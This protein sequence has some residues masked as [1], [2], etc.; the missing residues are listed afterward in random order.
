MKE[1]QVDDSSKKLEARSRS[2]CSEWTTY[3]Q[4]NI[5]HLRGGQ[6]RIPQSEKDRLH[7]ALQLPLPVTDFSIAA[8][9]IRELIGVFLNESVHEPERIGFCE[10]RAV[11]DSSLMISAEHLLTSFIAMRTFLES[12]LTDSQKDE[13]IIRIYCDS[14]HSLEDVI[15]ITR[16]A[17]TA[18]GG[19]REEYIEPLAFELLEFRAVLV[20]K[21]LELGAHIVSSRVQAEV[22]V[23]TIESEPEALILTIGEDSLLHQMLERQ[24]ELRKEVLPSIQKTAL[25]LVQHLLAFIETVR[26]QEVQPIGFD[27]KGMGKNKPISAEGVLDNLRETLYQLDDH[28]EALSEETPM[29]I[30]FRAYLHNMSH[31]ISAF[32]IALIRQ[33]R[34]GYIPEGV[35]EVV[36]QQAQYAFREVTQA[37][38]QL[39][40]IAN[41]DLFESERG[42]VVRTAGKVA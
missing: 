23:N 7:S 30:N 21:A 33:K 26:N 27:Q 14:H 31:F 36:Q 4:P 32:R 41:V 17:S 18:E 40:T 16:K 15:E 25:T 42:G 2:D 8:F 10:Q 12:E 24:A 13:H 20:S 3:S 37:V 34:N 35:C 28:F 5:P 39:T 19:V 6:P 1:N 38:K 9:K 22:S 29:D 11:E